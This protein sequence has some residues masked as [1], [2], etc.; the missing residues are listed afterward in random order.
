VRFILD[1]HSNCCM[2]MQQ[3]RDI[4]PWILIQL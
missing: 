3:R 2:S 4:N 1:F